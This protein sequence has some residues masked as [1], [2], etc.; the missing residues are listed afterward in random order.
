MPSD[1]HVASLSR[2]PVKLS[3]AD[4]E[5]YEQIYRRGWRQIRRWI[6]DGEDQ[7]KPCPLAHPEKMPDWWV[8]THPNRQVP[9]VIEEA[10]LA[11][12]RSIQ[13][14]APSA[15]RSLPDPASGP[16][17]RIP[18]PVPAMAPTAPGKAIDLESFDPEEGDRLRELKQIQAAKFAELRDALRAGEDCSVKETKYLK[19]SETVDKI[20]TRVTERMKKRGLFILRE[21]VERDLAAA[22]ELLRQS[23]AAMTRRVLELCSS[24]N[25]E[26]QAE[27]AAAVESAR[28]TEERMLCRL[29]CL[30]A[31]DLL[32]ELAA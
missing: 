16:V 14:P 10:A 25:A 15:E 26:Q 21:S 1:E 3:L 8:Q 20:E 24:L 6:D 18:A 17:T 19:L 23:Q 5:R 7:G 12:L 4:Q 28:A 22:A 11:A 31:G 9:H 2:A 29:E 32:K 13:A 30:T 27:V